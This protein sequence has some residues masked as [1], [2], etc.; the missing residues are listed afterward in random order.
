MSDLLTRPLSPVSDLT[1]NSDENDSRHPSQLT[2]AFVV[3]VLDH[4]NATVPT[5]ELQEDANARLLLFEHVPQEHRILHVG[6]KHIDTLG[7][8]REML[9]NAPTRRGKRY[10]ASAII[11]CNNR[12]EELFKLA[13]DFLNFLLWPRTSKRVSC[14][15]AHHLLAVKSAYKSKSP[16]VSEYS[17]ITIPETENSVKPQLIPFQ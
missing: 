12:E 1:D 7:I 8:L 11:C 13:S 14:F 2:G 9:D 15:L 16:T 3:T 10:V 6:N 4:M 5:A 17:T